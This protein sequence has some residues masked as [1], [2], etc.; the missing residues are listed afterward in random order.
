MGNFRSRNGSSE[1]GKNDESAD[2]NERSELDY[3][4]SGRSYAASF[5]NVCFYFRH[6]QFFSRLLQRGKNESIVRSQDYLH[7]IIHSGSNLAV[8]HVVWKFVRD[9]WPYLVKRY[10]TNDRNLGN[11]I[12]PV[13]AYFSTQSQLDEVRQRS[14]KVVGKLCDLRARFYGCRCEDFSNN[15]RK[16]A[17]VRR[18]EDEPP[19]EFKIISSGV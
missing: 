1:E 18:R 16:R 14:G 7:L 6:S 4:V 19:N 10:T 3:E 17:P 11:V 9:E 12:P 5:T 8:N 15:I 13:T 2:G